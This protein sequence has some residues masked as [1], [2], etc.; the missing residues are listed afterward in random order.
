MAAINYS[1]L[2]L[3]HPQF[4]EDLIAATPEVDPFIMKVEDLE[5]IAKKVSSIIKRS[6]NFSKWKKADIQS[7]HTALK[8][9]NA[10]VIEKQGRLHGCYLISRS[11]ED[12]T[13]SYGRLAAGT[14]VESDYITRQDFSIAI[15][16][17]NNEKLEESEEKH[18]EYLQ[19][20]AKRAPDFEEKVQRL[21]EGAIAQCLTDID[22]LSK[23]LNAEE[24][25][26]CNCVIL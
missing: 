20:E 9:I 6:P 12:V 23:R 11:P 21:Y 3:P 15:A 16:S 1:V 7:L 14:A 2:P 19:T 8:T 10:Y 24:R 4:V 22:R 18:L 5:N 26:C 17:I 25:R 13:N